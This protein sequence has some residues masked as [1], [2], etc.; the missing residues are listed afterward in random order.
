[1]EAKQKTLDYFIK[2]RKRSTN[3]D[4]LRKKG[5][6]SSTTGI[7]KSSRK[8]SFDDGSEQHII[9]KQ[10]VSHQQYYYILIR[11][12]WKLTIRQCFVICNYIDNV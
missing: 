11:K 4:N 7:N 8:L 5:L 6:R 1:M 12:H 10:K 9:K 2:S 3:E